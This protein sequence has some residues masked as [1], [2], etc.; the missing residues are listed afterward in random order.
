MSELN[1]LAAALAK[2]QGQIHAAPRD[3]ANPFFKSRYATLPAVR[4]AMQDAFADNGL[5][6]VQMP[7][8]EDGQLKLKT[9]LLHSSGQSLDCGT[10]AADVDLSNPQKSGSAISYFR[11][12]SLAAVSG[13]VTDTDDDGEAAA[14]RPTQAKRPPQPDPKEK[15]AVDA[16]VIAITSCKTLDDLTAIGERLKQEKPSIQNAVR[17]AYSIR[18]RQLEEKSNADS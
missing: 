5:S 6:V 10:L 7:S 18:K 3:A 8:V 4:E 2:A 14:G 9:M 1:E 15:A 17:N 16:T 11:R 13:V 12:Y